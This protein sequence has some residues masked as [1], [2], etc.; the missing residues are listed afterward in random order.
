MDRNITSAAGLLTSAA[1]LNNSAPRISARRIAGTKLQVMFGVRR[2]R[3]VTAASSKKPEGATED[4]AAGVSTADVAMTIVD[5]AAGA[6]KTH[7]A[8]RL[9]AAGSIAHRRLRA[10]KLPVLNLQPVNLLAD[11]LLPRVAGQ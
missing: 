10:E 9:G 5:G 8:M 3:V 4:G 2:T 7:A 6:T 11:L 1:A